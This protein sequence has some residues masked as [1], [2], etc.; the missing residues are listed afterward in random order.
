MYIIVFQI[1]HSA[2]GSIQDDK[3]AASFR[4]VEGVFSR[5]TRS[6]ISAVDFSS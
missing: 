4:M 1:L 6:Y 3:V 5:I 2:C